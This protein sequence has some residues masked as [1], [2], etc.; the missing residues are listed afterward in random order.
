[1]AV[2]DVHPSIEELTAF[3]LGTLDE[4]TQASIEAHV[5]ACTSCQE[6]AADAPADNLVELV[7]R[8]GARTGRRAD[9]FVD[10]AAQVQTPVPSAAVALTDALAPFA[11]PGSV[12]PEVPDALPP[13]L[14]R[15]E[16]YR[17]VRFIGAGGM[18]A[19]YEAE[20]RVMQRP[21]ALKVI[22]RA[23]T[24]NAAALERF[25]REVHA[26]ARLSHPNIVTTYDAED[27]GETHFLVMEYVEGTDLG[28]L[29]QERGPLPVDRACDY[30]RQ[31]AHGLQYAFEQGMVHRDLKP[32]NLMLTPGGCVKIL[33]FGL[34]RFAGEAAPG[35][36]TGSGMVLGTVDYIAPEQADNAHE[37]DIRSDIYSLGCTLYHLL[38]GRPPFPTGTPLQ[39]LTAH[40]NKKPLPLTEVRDDLPEGLMLVL[41]R[42][43][44]KNPKH[45]YQT[46]AEVA[47]ALAPFSISTAVSRS[48]RPRP[49]ARATDNGRTFIL[50]KKPA[51]VRKRRIFVI[52]TAIMLFLVAGLLGVSVYRIATDKGELIITTESD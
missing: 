22:N 15:H 51:L 30:V 20:H 5:A 12:R 3:T 50:E 40:V 43:M 11:F 42:M 29:V 19:V 2:A 45:R 7:R 9:T 25:R 23:Y 44:A 21:V 33:D 41:E 52:A 36:V 28:R 34:A 10:T 4:E 26:A 39:K 16:R 31:A 18:G 8:L 32:H 35:G 37:A 38:A 1:M 14:A 24:A 13:E 46:P 48:P 6:R 47:N 27:A 17:V 49:R